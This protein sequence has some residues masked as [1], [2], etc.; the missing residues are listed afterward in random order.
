MI[1]LPPRQVST[2]CPHRLNSYHQQIFNS[3][4]TDD[5]DRHWFLHHQ[6]CPCCRRAIIS[7]SWNTLGSNYRA[8]GYFVYPR[9]VARVPLPEVVPEDFA[10][11][12]HEACLVMSDSPNA[13]GALSRRCLQHILREVA[14]VKPAK[15]SNEIDEVLPSLPVDIAGALDAIRHLGNFAAHPVKSTNSGG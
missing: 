12:Y 8:G 14:K 4:I 3:T 9:A 2:K 10:K 5:K 1:T 13:S 7:L 11:D 15:L 6:V